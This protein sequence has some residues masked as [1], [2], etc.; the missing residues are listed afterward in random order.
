[1]RSPLEFF[2]HLLH[3]LSRDGHCEPLS[4]LRSPVTFPESTKVALISKTNGQNRV[5]KLIAISIMAFR[6]RYSLL[7]DCSS[8]DC[9]LVC[10]IRLWKNQHNANGPIAMCAMFLPWRIPFALMVVDWGIAVCFD[11][12][13]IFW[14]PHV[15]IS[16]RCGLV[17]KF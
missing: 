12:V 10:S 6:E 7:C 11:K 17:W 15:F 14:R 8:G 13:M 4:S 3:L 2:V 5:L 9:Q 16:D 1:M